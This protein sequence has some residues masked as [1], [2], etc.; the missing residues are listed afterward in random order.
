VARAVSVGELSASAGDAD[1][2]SRA[3]ARPKSRTLT[4]PSSAT[5]MFAGLRSRWMMPLLV[6]RFEG[7][8]DLPADRSRIV[9]RKR[10][11]RQPIGERRTLDEL[12]HQRMNAGRVLEAVNLG[13]VRVIQG[14]EQVGLATEPREPLRVGG[15]TGW[16]DFERDIARQLGVARAV[17]LAH[18]SGSDGR[19]HLVRAYAGAWIQ[20]CAGILARD[21]RCTL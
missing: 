17:D 13:D 11:R 15:H 7:L 8:G 19:D 4:V 1:P 3:L 21:H 2:E 18:P 16:E 9:E 12:H 14:R 20:G 5:L 10:S 6:C